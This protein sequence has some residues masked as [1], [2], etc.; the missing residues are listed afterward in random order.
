MTHKITDENLFLTIAEVAKILRVD[1]TTVRRWCNDGI[2]EAVM[3]PKIFKRQT[4]RIRK[5]TVEQVLNNTNVKMLED[6]LEQ[7]QELVKEIKQV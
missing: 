5:S 6:K 3:L 4:F 7:I 1:H 2:L